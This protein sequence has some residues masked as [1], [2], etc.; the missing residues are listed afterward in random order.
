MF[1][2]IPLSSTGS[3]D[4]DGPPAQVTRDALECR[5]DAAH[6][7]SYALHVRAGGG[8]AGAWNS[9]GSRR[10]LPTLWVAAWG[11]LSNSWRRVAVGVCLASRV[12]AAGE[13]RPASGVCEDLLCVSFSVRYTG[14]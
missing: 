3:T 14:K 10:L 4:E 5:P 8:S 7:G 2:V 1:G 6:H 12:E 11:L 13:E 9:L